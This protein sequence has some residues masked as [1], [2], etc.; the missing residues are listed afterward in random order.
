MEKKFYTFFIEQ[1]ENKD[2]LAEYS[3]TT[4]Y[5]THEDAQIAYFEK[6]KNVSAS[7]KAG[8]HKY[9]RAEIR[10]SFGNVY[11]QNKLGERVNPEPEP[12]PEV[13]D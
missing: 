3:G 1:I 7:V 2:G 11:E 12:T 5:T 8:T 4:G 13:N 6:L 9:C 10:D